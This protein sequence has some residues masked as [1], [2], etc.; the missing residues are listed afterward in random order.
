MTRAIL[1]CALLIPAAARADE[2]H[3]GDPFDRGSWNLH[4]YGSYAD[5][6]RLGNEQTATLSGGVGYY[7]VDQ[8]SINVEAVGYRFETRGSH[9]PAGG[10]NGMFRWHFFTRERF[11]LYLDGGGGLLY[12]DDQIPR[13]G[14][15]FNYAARV[16][17]GATVRLHED[18]HL[19]TGVRYFHL[20]NGDIHG[21]PRNPSIDA[22]ETYLGVMWTF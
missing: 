1:F 8:F 5:T 11:S 22:V 18:L 13:F 19:M 16:G 3:A 14:T 20:S 9:I 7:L 4:L 17:G 2:P 12:A 6:F 10:L 15:H 21:R